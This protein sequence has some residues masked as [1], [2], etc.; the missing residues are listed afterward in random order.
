[1]K[2]RSFCTD[3][4]N[5]ARKRKKVVNLRGGKNLFI[6]KKCL[7]SVKTNRNTQ[8]KKKSMDMIFSITVEKEGKETS[9]Y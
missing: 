8:Y 3:K 5:A 1:M 9:I 2:L 6:I 7:T 4:I